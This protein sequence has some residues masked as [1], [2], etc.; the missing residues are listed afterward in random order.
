M[1]S[2]ISKVLY[3]QITRLKP[4][5]HAMDMDIAAARKSQDALGALGARALKNRIVFEPEPF[6]NFEADWALPCNGTAD[7]GVILYL[8]GGSYTAGSLAY[9][10]GFGGVLAEKME[11]IVLCVAY[12]LAP[13]H[14]FPSALDD[15]VEAYLRICK[16][17]PSQRISIVGESA[18][19]G[20]TF[21][22]AVKLKEMDVPAPACVVALSPWT[23]LTCS[24]SSF[25][26]NAEVDPSLFLD[27]LRTSADYYSL[28][29]TTNPLV[30]PLF[31]DL[32]NM[33]PALVYAGSLELLLDDSV[34]ITDRYGK[35]GSA[36]ELHI[37]EGMWHVFVIFGTPEAKEALERIREFIDEKTLV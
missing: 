29:D 2:K 10:K 28:G 25:E 24:G 5:L 31:A 23:D 22:L 30:S 14:P 26:T 15:A 4:V 18:G 33:P 9:S 21:A 11:R 35:F 13:E 20:L 17:Y 19:G 8:H 1:P 16:K 12:R 27:S 6:D 34:R 3:K 36:C 7:G 37:V 32:S